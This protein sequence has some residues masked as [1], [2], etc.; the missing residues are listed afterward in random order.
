MSNETV[1]LKE[2]L[3]PVVGGLGGNDSV[4]LMSG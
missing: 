4:M 2:A 3:G 1:R